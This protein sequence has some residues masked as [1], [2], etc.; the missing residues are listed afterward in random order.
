V[1]RLGELNSRAIAIRRKLNPDFIL[2]TP[3]NPARVSWVP[4]TRQ[5]KTEYVGYVVRVFE[6]HFR[7]AVGYVDQCAVS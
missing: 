4:V 5:P 1:V 2:A 3:D 7:A 6:L